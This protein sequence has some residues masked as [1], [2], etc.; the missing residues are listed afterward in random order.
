MTM[1]SL[2]GRKTITS[3]GTIEP[4]GTGSVHGLL[5]IKAL[6]AN[7]GIMEIGSSGTAASSGYQLSAKEELLLYNVEDL[8]DIWVDST[9][10]GE[11]VC[12]IR[13]RAR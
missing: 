10:N 6:A 1:A 8:W 5:Y 12:W 9:V 2:S 3:S 4:L 7:T 11:G 13:L